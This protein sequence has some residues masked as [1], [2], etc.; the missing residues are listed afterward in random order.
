VTD[1][2]EW[3]GQVNDRC[4][5]STYNCERKTDRSKYASVIEG[6]P[7]GVRGYRGAQP[8]STP[9]VSTSMLTASVQKFD[10]AD[11]SGRVRNNR[12]D[13]VCCDG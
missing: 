1:R 11:R 5:E 13:G 6:Y 9:A 10:I 3:H 12:P 4:G 2:G 7:S 8:R